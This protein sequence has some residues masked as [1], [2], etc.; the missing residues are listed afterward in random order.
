MDVITLCDGKYVVQHDNGMN[1][2]ALRYGEEWRSLTGDGLVLAMAQRITELETLLAAAETPVWS[3]LT[4]GLVLAAEF[5]PKATCWSQATDEV[6]D[7]C[8]DAR[9]RAGMPEDQAVDFRAFNTPSQWNTQG[10]AG[11]VKFYGMLAPEQRATFC[12]RWDE[13]LAFT[14]E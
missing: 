10:I 14:P 2:K 9:E 6:R 11:I 1:F 7:M 4:L 13:V 3:P 12:A 5:S 8:R